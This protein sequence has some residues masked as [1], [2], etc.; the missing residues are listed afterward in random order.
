MG[1]LMGMLARFNM[2]IAD[3]M[4]SVDIDDTLGDVVETVQTVFRILFGLIGLA[5][6]V[7]AIWVGFRVASAEDEGKRKE[8]KKQLL[9]TIIAIF[10]VVLLVVVFEILFSALAPG[11]ET[12]VIVN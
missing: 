2:Q 3:L 12:D 9:W 10:G 7:F 8:A 4:G 6:I 11:A 5:A 1:N